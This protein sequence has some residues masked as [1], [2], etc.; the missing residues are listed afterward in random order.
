MPSMQEVPPHPRQPPALHQYQ[1]VAQ[2]HPQAQRFRHLGA[3]ILDLL[4]AV[5]LV[6]PGVLHRLEQ[7]PSEQDQVLRTL[8]LVDPVLGQ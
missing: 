5:S 6:L 4:S 8:S 7:G 3:E 1:Q 2:E